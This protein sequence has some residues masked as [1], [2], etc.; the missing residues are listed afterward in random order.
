MKFQITVL[1]AICLFSVPAAWAQLSITTGTQVKVAGNI[2]VVLANTSLINNGVCNNNTGRFVFSGNAAN[3]IGGNTPIQ[4]QEIEIA[5]TNG[6]VI[7][8][9]QNMGVSGKIVFTTSNIDLSN[10]TIDLATTGFLEGEN[11]SSRIFTSGNGQ[12]VATANLSAP[13]AANPGAL[14]AFITS[15]QNLGTVVIKR[16]HQ[17]QINGNGNGS[18]ILRYYDIA[19]TNNNGLNATLRLHYFDA[20]LNALPEANLTL[21]RSTNN[22]QWSNE[23][24]TAKDGAANWVEK[25]NI[26]SF[27]RWTLSTINNPLPVQLVHWSG[28]II[29]CKA[30]LVWETATEQGSSHFEI[31]HSHDGLLFTK[32]GRVTAAGNAATLQRYRFHAALDQGEHLF[33][34]RMIDRDGN[35]KLSTVLRLRN[36]CSSNGY[37]VFPNPVKN[38]VWVKGLSAGQ[39]IVLSNAGGQQVKVWQAVSP[40]TGLDLVSLPPGV[41]H[42]RILE[43][44]A[45]VWTASLIKE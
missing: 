23:M 6:A 15:A 32:L 42:I 18:S 17:S 1:T 39:E 16:G 36:N 25:N 45:V 28:S 9:Q 37:M 38:T 20:E 31:E 44:G 41:Y 33:R 3:V 4:A 34:L 10:Y 43:G 26:A 30:E 35:Q 27:S 29:N 19:S 14:G 21:W 11:E 13:V 8:L 24:F 7:S 22:Q 2:Q 5:K 40:S 12:V